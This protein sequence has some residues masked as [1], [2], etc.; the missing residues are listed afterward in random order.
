[1]PLPCCLQR[2]FKAVNPLDYPVG[3]IFGGFA[4]KRKNMF[5][6]YFACVLMDPQNA[7]SARCMGEGP[8]IW[9]SRKINICARKRTKDLHSH[10]FFVASGQSP[11]HAFWIWL[12]A[13]AW[14]PSDPPER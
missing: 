9:I 13:G 8:D 1:M 7:V 12:V 14:S 10:S 5:S 4:R 11:K 3:E 6:N 2:V